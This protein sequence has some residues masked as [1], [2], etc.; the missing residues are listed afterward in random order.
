[1]PDLMKTLGA[2]LALSSLLMT[3]TMTGQ[4]GEA[5]DAGRAGGVYDLKTRTLEGEDADLADWKGEVTLV[6]NVASKCGLTPQYTK[7]QELHEAFAP[8]GFAVLAFPCNDFGAQE[9]GTPDE[10]RTFC[11]SNYGVTFPMFEKLQTKAGPGQSPLYARLAEMTGELPSWNFGKYLV[12]RDG[13]E[14]TYFS[15]RTAPDDAELIAAIE[16]ALDG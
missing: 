8:R 5:A 3:A 13:T 10:I 14:V 11:T 2:A 16:A 6:V 15:S 12:S 1:M 4:D 7:L 9:P